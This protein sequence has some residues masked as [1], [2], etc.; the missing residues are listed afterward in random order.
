MN[1]PLLNTKSFHA[2][3]G[4]RL[5]HDIRYIHDIH[6]TKVNPGGMKV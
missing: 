2:L 1:Y 4:H 6:D 5:T 3:Q